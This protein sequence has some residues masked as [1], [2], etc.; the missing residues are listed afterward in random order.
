MRIRR[1]IRTLTTAEKTTF[2]NGLKLLK[3]QGKYDQYVQMHVSYMHQI[4]HR[5]RFLPWHCEYIRQLE[6]DLQVATGDPLFA[7]PYWDWTA[8]A[9][10]TIG[11]VWKNDL[12]GGDGNPVTGP[13]S[14]TAGWTV[15]TGGRWS[16]GSDKQ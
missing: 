15:H 11:S 1:D 12:M 7:L 2:V 4:H 8:D 3:S 6:A 16:E 14:P 5:P 13:F 10:N 9:P